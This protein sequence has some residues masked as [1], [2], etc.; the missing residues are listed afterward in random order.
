M[1][2]ASRISAFPSPW[3]VQV[4][5]QLTELQVEL[6][7]AELRASRRDIPD[8][9][10]LDLRR[11]GVRGCL[12]PRPVLK[13]KPLDVSRLDYLG[14]PAWLGPRV[15]DPPTVQVATASENSYRWYRLRRSAGVLFSTVATIIG[16]L[17]VASGAYWVGTSVSKLLLILGAVVTFLAVIAL[18]ISGWRAVT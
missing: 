9:L 7:A 3:A 17:L 13:V 5:G 6:P 14:I 8:F 1:P 11:P 2:R 4:N 18:V 10:R 15:P 16:G 12:A